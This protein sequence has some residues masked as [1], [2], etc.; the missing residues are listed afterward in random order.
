MADTFSIDPKS[1]ALLAMDFQNAIVEMAAGN[2]PGLLE[3]MSEL[4][5][6]A[7]AAGVMVIYVVVGFRPGF[8]EI[9]MRNKSFGAIRDSGRFSP[10]DAGTAIHS[11][12]A[13]ADSDVVV[14]KH[15]VSAF[16]GTD[17]EIVLRANG[18]E[19]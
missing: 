16:S 7:R 6:A 18:I 4:L 14:T 19:T 8:P 9:S 17:L 2:S 13:P 12:V 10:G 11:A 5:E 15:R 1:T 3:R